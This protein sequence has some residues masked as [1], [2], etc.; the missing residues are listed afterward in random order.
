MSG[1]DTAYGV[2]GLR[3]WYAM[4]GT[5]LGYAATAAKNRKAMAAIKQEMQNAG[6]KSTPKSNTSSPF[7]HKSALQ[8]TTSHLF[9]AERQ[10][11]EPNRQRLERRARAGTNLLR[12]LLR[13]ELGG[14]RKRGQQLE[15]RARAGEARV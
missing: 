10:E 9:S 13:N 15:S 11:R 8:S 14:I 6:Y 5:E 7:Q 12:N 4:P 2:V 1:T 3:V